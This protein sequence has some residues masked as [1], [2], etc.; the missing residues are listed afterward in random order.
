MGSKKILAIF[1]NVALFGQER[2][3]IQ[4]FE[5]LKDAGHD[6][7]LAVNDRGFQWHIQPEIEKRNLKFK[8]I[9][10][11][12]NLKKT[13]SFK[14][15]KMYFTDIFK[16]NFQLFKLIKEYNPDV[17]HVCNDTQ[18]L[19]LL[20]VLLFTSIPIIYRLGDIPPIKSI[21]YR[22]IW[23]KL[24]TKRINKF[25]CISEFVKSELLK[26]NPV[27]NNIDI[28]YNLPTKRIILNT[29]EDQ[30]PK[31]DSNLITFV[32]IG[33]IN[34][35]KGVRILVN[36]FEDL[37]D[38]FANTRLLLA[39]DTEH[40]VLAKELM[41]EANL[42]KYKNRIQFLGKVNNIDALLNIG[43]IG[44]FPSIY[45]EPLSNVIG[46]AKKNGK[47]SIIFNSGG[48]PE[49]VQHN[50]DGYISKTKNKE[51][52]LEGL[53]YYVEN[54]EQLK[55][56]GD[57]ALKSLVSLGLNMNSFTSKWLKVYE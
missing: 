18:V 33:Q 17:I 56:Q 32:Y 7:L 19:T 3:N 13:K 45:N 34:E 55:I 14:T 44:V 49:L 4:V 40:S 54:P 12:W 50:Y 6:I 30:L 35:I 8:K 27:L 47:A 41:K 38:R 51:G 36:A 24:I 43:D 53:T 46:E 57:N 25:V 15:I 37:N 1:G 28:I 5:I 10:F 31:K 16:S 39:G 42:I 29:E 26:I 2:A 20:P 21:S 48:M 52:L 22:F 9:R 11:S 23:S